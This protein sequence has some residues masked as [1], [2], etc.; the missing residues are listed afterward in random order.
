MNI[1]CQ[2]IIKQGK[3]RG[4]KCC[5]V[6]R[7]CHNNSHRDNDPVRTQPV[8][9]KIITRKENLEPNNEAPSICKYCHKQFGRKN[10]MYRHQKYHCK[11]KNSHHHS[12]QKIYQR[13]NPNNISKDIEKCVDYNDIKTYDDQEFDDD[14]EINN[15]HE[16]KDEQETD[17]G[18]NNNEKMNNLDEG[19]SEDSFLTNKSNITRSNFDERNEFTIDIESDDHDQTLT[20]LKDTIDPILVSLLEQQQ[21]EIAA[22]KAAIQKKNID[23]NDNGYN[24][25][26]VTQNK[27]QIHRQTYNANSNNTSN[28]H[29]NNSNNTNSNNNTNNNYIQIVCVGPKDD[30]FQILSD[31]MGT[32]KARDYILNC[33]K[34]NL[35]GDLNLLK[36]IYFEGKEPAEYPIRF[37]D[38]KRNKVE[39]ID[40]N[41][42]VVLDQYGKELSKRLCSNLQNGY[43]MQVNMILENN[44]NQNEDG[45]FMDEFEIH[46]CQNHIYELSSKKYRRKLLSSLPEKFDYHL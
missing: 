22:L 34:N 10:N 9:K 41:K 12:V 40:E 28:S 23:K 14:K 30:F 33:A 43:L 46:S 24:K 15:Y 8:I 36:K 29:N 27:S 37:L 32:E 26:S 4:K 17:L 20:H 44:F 6:N 31:R 3:N 18:S 45:K 7:Y 39:F 21:M 5:Q 1:D 35:E 11:A 38:K 25:G 13:N 19:L 2:Y 16:F 42:K